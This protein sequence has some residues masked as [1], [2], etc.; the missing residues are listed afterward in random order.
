[1][2]DDADPPTEDDEARVTIPPVADVELQ[3]T[4]T[5]PPAFIGD[6]ATFSIRVSNAGPF[7]TDGVEVT[8]VL[9]LGLEYQSSEPSVGTYDPATGVWT[10][11]AL[12][13]GD[14]QF[15]TIF[16]RVANGGSLQLSAEVTSASTMDVDSTPANS[17]IGEDDQ[18]WVSLAL[19]G[20]TI[21]DRVW[22]DLDRDGV[23][24]PGEPGLAG[25]AIQVVWAGLNGTFGDADDATW[26]AVTDES[27]GWSLTGLPAGEVRVSIDPATLPSALLEPLFDPDGASTPNTAVLNL[28]IGEDRDDVDFAYG[29]PV[30]ATS[31]YSG[32]LAFTGSN[33]SSMIAAA[34]TAVVMGVA[35]AFASRLRL[36]R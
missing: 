34:L 30:P 24:D 35:L 1:V 13:V 18:D 15:L 32:P 25:V 6:T 16:V 21:G 10:V 12:G 23:S 19:A 14:E 20:V 11:G 28:M 4:L 36:Q 17:L 29:D 31:T 7:A 27:G 5:D 26:S 2:I 3:V 9:P 22:N 8:S 33:A